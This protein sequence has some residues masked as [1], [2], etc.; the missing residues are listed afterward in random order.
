MSERDAAIDSYLQDNLE[1]YVAETA[2]LCAQPSVSARAEGTQAQDGLAQAGPA[3]DLREG[4]AEQL[5]H[6][7]QPQRPGVRAIPLD[8]Q[9][10]GASREQVQELREDSASG[11]HRRI[12]GYN[13][14][15]RREKA[16]SGMKSCTLTS[17]SFRTAGPKRHRP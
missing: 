3:G 7:R 8:R 2:R 17:E 5:V 11:V 4:H 12:V 6:A 14:P 15:P 10:E 16:R 13:A 1:K 9:V